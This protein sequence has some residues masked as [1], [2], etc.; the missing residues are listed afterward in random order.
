M[1]YLTRH[2]PINRNDYKT[3][4]DFFDACEEYLEEIKSIG[5]RIVSTPNSSG[6]FKVERLENKD[7]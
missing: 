3:E 6:Y 4:A 5:Y 1:T 7:D 2:C